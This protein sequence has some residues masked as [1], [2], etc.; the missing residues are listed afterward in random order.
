MKHLT[1]INNEWK[2][3]I[4]PNI[5]EQE[6]SILQNND[7]S[8]LELQK[9]TIQNIKNRSLQNATIEDINLAEN[10]YNSH[11]IENSTLISVDIILPDGRGLINCRVNSEH[12][13]IRF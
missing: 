7:S 13:Q 8:N 6:H 9:T 10:L 2:V 5:T 11:K 4:D 12:K 1:L 3:R